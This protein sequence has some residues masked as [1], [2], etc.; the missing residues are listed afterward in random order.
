[1]DDIE[2]IRRFEGRT[3]RPRWDSISSQAAQNAG[4]LNWVS[5]PAEAWDRDAAVGYTDMV[6]KWAIK[7]PRV[8]GAVDPE[9]TSTDPR[10]TSLRRLFDFH[11]AK[12]IHLQGLGIS[13]PRVPS[14][15]EAAWG[16][17]KQALADIP[18]K[19]PEVGKWALIVLGV[20]L[21]LLIATRR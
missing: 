9:G 12:M 10:F 14:D 6:M 3:L 7:I 11:V 20:L 5:A 2:S 1:M 21:V 16:G 4:V 19:A 8:L 13:T 15:L 17:F 18:E